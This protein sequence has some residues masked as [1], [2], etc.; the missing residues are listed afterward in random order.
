MSGQTIHNRLNCVEEKCW[1][2]VSKISLSFVQI[3]HYLPGQKKSPITKIIVIRFFEVIVEILLWYILSQAVFGKRFV[4]F[5]KRN[6]NL[7]SSVDMMCTADFKIQ[8]ELL[9]NVYFPSLYCIERVTKKFT[10]PQVW[11]HPYSIVSNNNLQTW[12]LN[13][14]LL[15]SNTVE[16][17]QL[18][19]TL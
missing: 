10:C 5:L 13:S 7:V 8:N 6:L 16:H 12:D 15:C 9:Q 11:H 1:V 3:L 14:Y 18:Q 4:I 2:Y 19:K 17:Y